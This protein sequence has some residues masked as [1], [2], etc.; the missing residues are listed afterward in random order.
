MKQRPSVNPGTWIA[1]GSKVA[2]NMANDRIPGRAAQMSFYFFLSVFPILLILMAVLGL[3]LDAQSLVRETILQRLALLV[4]PS[5]VE[6]FTGLLDHL[7]AQP[8]APLTW[9]IVLSLWAGSSGMVATIRGLNRAYEVKE[10]RS[11]W[12]RRLLGIALTL[13]LMLMMATTMVLLTYGV[14]LAESLAQRMGLGPAFLQA[15]RVA[16][17]P[18]IFAI[19]V[20]GFEQ[21]Y[22]LGPNRPAQRWRWWSP[23]A[24]VAAALWLAVSLALKLYVTSIGSYN[25]AYGSLGGVIVLL[26][27]FYFTAIAILAGADINAQREH[28]RRRCHTEKA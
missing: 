20:V 25:V 6:L 10:G 16:Q 18:V 23:G 7:A 9:G 5:V 13:L 2:R 24:L 19:A 11:W 1:W 12:K 17:W 3:F 14:P 4:S 28:E 26:L 27:W 15:W 8:G 21:L 22:H